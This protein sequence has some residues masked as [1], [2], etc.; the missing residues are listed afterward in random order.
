[1]TF[2]RPRRKSLFF[3]AALA[4]ACATGA[5][6]AGNTPTMSFAV[7]DQRELLPDEQVQHVLNRL[8]F[9]ARP[10]DAAAVR[11]MGVDK[12]IARQLHPETI[13]DAGVTSLVARYPALAS[14]RADLVDD[15]RE[16]RQARQQGAARGQQRPPLD[17]QRAAP[18]L[19]TP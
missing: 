12:W 6:P 11:A 9:G 18:Q 13:D 4:S 8:A 5:G 17:V 1:M 7:T 10:G 19:H 16:A 3:G 15:F 2:V 14:Q